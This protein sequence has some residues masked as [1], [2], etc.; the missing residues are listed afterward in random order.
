MLFIL[1]FSSSICDVSLFLIFL[2]S[3]SNERSARDFWSVFDKL[4]GASIE[5]MSFRDVFSGK[6]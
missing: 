5:C 4:K 3:S 1:K 6:R 2:F